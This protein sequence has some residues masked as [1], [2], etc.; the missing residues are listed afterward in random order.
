MHRRALVAAVLAAVAA[1]AGCTAERTEAAPSSSAVARSTAVAAPSSSAVRADPSLNGALLKAAASDDAA[2]V[3]DLLGRGAQIEAR[4]ADG[5]TPVVVATKNRAVAAAGALIDAGADV[6]AKDD[7]QDSAYLYA[8]AEGYDDILEMTLRHGADVRSV[9][10]FGG[11]ALIPAAEHGSVTTVRRLIE[12]GVDVD[13]VNTP[14]WTALQEAVVYGD[15]SGRYQE[16]VRA[17]LD[18]GADPDIRD[19]NGRTVQDNAR[20]LGQNAIVEILQE[21]RPVR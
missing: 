9:N 19:A 17:L 16:T 1:T 2:A 8:G 4:G 15:G 7:M 13:H 14:G 11:T 20:R 3:R 6:N 12:A 21:D 5:R 10:R 18:A